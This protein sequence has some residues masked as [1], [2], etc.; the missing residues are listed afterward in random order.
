MSKAILILEKMPK[1]C[2]ECSLCYNGIDCA[3]NGWVVCSDEGQTNRSSDCPLIPVENLKM[4]GYDFEE[5][6]IFA[7]ACRK[8]DIKE[9]DLLAFIRNSASA[10]NYIHKK[11]LEHLDEKINIENK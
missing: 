6:L 4:C 3:I 2:E 9:E 1:S 5:L 10:F 8:A 11:L 7:E